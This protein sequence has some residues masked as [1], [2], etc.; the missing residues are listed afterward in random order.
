MLVEL[1]RY[2]EAIA[3]YEEFMAIHTDPY[4]KVQ[5]KAGMARAYFN[6]G[7]EQRAEEFLKQ[8]IREAD[9]VEVK[10]NA[11]EQA[12]QIFRGSNDAKAI[13]FMREAV[14]YSK[15]LEDYQ[16]MYAVAE[17]GWILSEAGEHEEALQIAKNNVVQYNEDHHH[18]DL[19]HHLILAGKPD[20]AAEALKLALEKFSDSDY[21]Y[22]D[23]PAQIAETRENLKRHKKG[24]G[25]FGKWF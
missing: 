16:Y 20:E 19:I 6:S 2:P 7:E 14:E 17:L 5:A 12:A 23:Y 22:A 4:E 10:Y 8:A 3:K 1:G 21:L 13:A 11:A 18:S 9:D 25:F 24:G 15:H